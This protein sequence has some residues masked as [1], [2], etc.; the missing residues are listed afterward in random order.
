MC[1]TT[2]EAKLAD[3][4]RAS[5]LCFSAL[6]LRTP[7]AHIP[8]YTHYNPE[9]PEIGVSDIQK[10]Y[11]WGG[12]RAGPGL[13]NTVLGNLDIASKPPGGLNQRAALLLS[14][15][16]NSSRPVNYKPCCGALTHKIIV[17]IDF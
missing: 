11:C 6:F 14:P 2:A 4:R 13:G 17:N 15:T 5:V 3:L 10:V 12:L 7:T 1:R 9:S 8:H 16:T